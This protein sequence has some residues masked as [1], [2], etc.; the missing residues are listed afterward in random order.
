GSRCRA[1]PF[2]QNPRPLCATAGETRLVRRVECETKRTRNGNPGR[3]QQRATAGKTPRAS[4]GRTE[5]RIAV[6]G[7]N[8][9]GVGHF[10]KNQ[11]MNPLVKKEIRLLLPSWSAALSLV[12]LL[13]WFWK[14]PDAS[15]AW[16]PFLVFFGMIMLAVD[17]FGRECSLG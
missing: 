3:R 1:R 7:G 15:F 6:A 14:D 10:E 8:F 16:T 2:P 17:S 12:V 4:A 9:R 5:L 13:P 11:R